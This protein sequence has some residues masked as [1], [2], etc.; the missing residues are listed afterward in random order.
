MKCTARQDPSDKTNAGDRLSEP[1]LITPQFRHIK[2]LARLK[3]TAEEQREQNLIQQS[4]QMQTAFSFT[5]AALFMATSIC[6]QYREPLSLNFFLVAISCISALLIASLVFASVAQW[7]WKTDSFPDI[8]T[9]KKENLDSDEWQNLCIEAYQI[10]QWINLVGTVQ[11]EKTRLNDLRVKLIMASM[12]CFYA[13]IATIVLFFV[14]G[15]CKI[16]K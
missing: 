16:A 9:I 4:S 2:E 15:I 6:V 12:V 1:D 13:A 5:T 14:I 11:K 3:Y 7:R 10:D 8:E